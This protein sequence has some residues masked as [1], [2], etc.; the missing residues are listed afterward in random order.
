MG[1]RKR[2]GK[3]AL[4]LV[5]VSLFILTIQVGC[6]K[7]QAINDFS[8]GTTDFASSYDSIFPGSYDT[9]LSTAEIRNIILELGETPSISPLTQLSDDKEQCSGFRN[10]TEAFSQTSLG[11]N[12]FG[13]ALNLLATRSQLG[14]FQEEVFIPQF[15]GINENAAETVP[16]LGGH[17]KEIA[18]VNT[19]KDYFQSF[20]VQKTPQEMILETNP[21][22]T[23]TL[24]LLEVFSDIYQVQLDNYERN[25]R[26][27]DT[28]L[29]DVR[30]DDPVKRTFVMNR[31]RDQNGRQQLLDNYNEALEAV[32][33]SYKKL[34]QR[35]EL[36]TPHYN[37]PIF[38]QD[39]KEFL[40]K[41][42]NLI[43]QSKI[44][45]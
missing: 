7:P 21:Q 42:S 37:D 2:F 14:S 28:L 41:I 32:K 26:V 4:G 12:D 8:T 43:Q 29:V 1:T 15:T 6:A 20:F 34:Y 3:P 9:C 30:S 45:S 40:I 25:I 31:S 44:I 5:I 23:S 33:E 18:Q 19:W 22:V 36:S 24:A 10:G 27:L 16:E 35:S 11:L 17:T 13:R 38:Q 39:M